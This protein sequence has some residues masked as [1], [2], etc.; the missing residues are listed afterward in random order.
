MDGTIQSNVA[1]A[2][3]HIAAISL[4][5]RVKETKPEPIDTTKVEAGITS[6]ESRL[7]KTMNRALGEL[8]LD[9]K[10]LRNIA[11]MLDAQ[12][13]SAADSIRGEGGSKSSGE[14]KTTIENK[15]GQKLPSSRPGDDSSSKTS[16]KTSKAKG[17]TS[18]GSKSSSSKPKQEVQGPPA[19]EVQGPPAP[20]S[21]S[22]GKGTASSQKKGS[23]GKSGS[24]K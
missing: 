16:K 18:K 14:K 21:S 19:P 5:E 17:S 7:R 2:E 12:D 4:A 6:S 11:Q 22:T 15:S 23:A 3:G 8:A 20:K 24:S 10:N 9:M 1:T 13:E